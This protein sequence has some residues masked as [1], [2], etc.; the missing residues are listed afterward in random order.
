MFLKAL[1]D[2]GERDCRNGWPAVNE[3]K[4]EV[5]QLLGRISRT[6]RWNCIILN[7]FLLFFSFLSSYLIS[8]LISFLIQ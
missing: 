8:Y 7:T 4:L 5:L 6:K 2:S 1:G 3:T